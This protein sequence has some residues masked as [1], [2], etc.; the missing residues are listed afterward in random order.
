MDWLIL[1]IGMFRSCAIMGQIERHMGPKAYHPVGKLG[2][3]RW[4]LNLRSRSQHGYVDCGT[5]ATRCWR[6]RFDHLGQYL[7]QRPLQHEVRSNAIHF[8]RVLYPRRLN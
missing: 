8:C 2:V 7:Y 1:S 4:Q 6:R 5:R 3:S